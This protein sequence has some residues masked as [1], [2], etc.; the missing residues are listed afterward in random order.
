MSERYI[1]TVTHYY[2]GPG[3]AVVQ[4]AE[5]GIDVGDLV[6]IIGHTTDFSDRVQSMEVEHGRVV[7]ASPGEEV[8]I[9]VAGR[10]RPHD[11]LYKV[12]PDDEPTVH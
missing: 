3:V 5:N 8:A 12:V 11:H 2:K 9:K 10:A 1:G 7:H 4:V 6:H